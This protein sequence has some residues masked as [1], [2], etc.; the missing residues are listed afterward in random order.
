MVLGVMDLVR[1]SYSRSRFWIRF[2]F[3]VQMGMGGW[4]TSAVSAERSSL[5]CAV[6]N[7]NDTDRFVRKPLTDL[8]CRTRGLEDC[9]MVLTGTSD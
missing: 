1:M 6:T 5:A 3:D 4:Q 2:K 8:G 9:H 7:R